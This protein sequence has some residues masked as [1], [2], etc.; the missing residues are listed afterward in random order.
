M[1]F[2][3]QE[4]PKPTDALRNLGPMRE[5]VPIACDTCRPGSQMGPYL[6]DGDNY[7]CAL[8]PLRPIPCQDVFPFLGVTGTGTQVPYL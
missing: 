8:L 2:W 4:P 1:S 6:K 7:S 5:S 3:K